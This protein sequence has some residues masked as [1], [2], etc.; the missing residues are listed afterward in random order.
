LAHLVER[1]GIEPGQTTA[2][3][4]VTLEFAECLGLCDVAPAMLVNDTVHGDMTKE[5]VDDLLQK[6]A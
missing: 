4:R 3:G 2:D 5:K 1:L 6:M